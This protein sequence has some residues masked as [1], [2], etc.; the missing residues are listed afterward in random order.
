MPENK[1]YVFGVADITVGDE[2]EQIKFNGKDYL[3]SEGGELVLTPVY[4]EFQ[5]QD[6]GETIVERRLAGW[7]GSLSIAAGQEDAKIL[8]LALGSVEPITDSTSGD[9]VGS[10]DAA[11]GTKAKGR[12]VTIHPRMLPADDKSKDFT[13][14][15]VTSTEGL[16]RPYGAEQG[17]ITITLTM[18]PREG[19]DASKPGNFFFRGPVDPNGTEA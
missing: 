8:D 3:Q 19:F 10:M 4:T 9:T 18:Q 17:T 15:N 1:E 7:E 16:T 13:I 5:F 6:F 12:K 11:I 2:E 14:Y